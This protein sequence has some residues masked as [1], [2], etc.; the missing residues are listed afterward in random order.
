MD[1]RLIVQYLKKD[2]IDLSE[3]EQNVSALNYKVSMYAL[4]HESSSVDENICDL[5]E[6]RDLNRNVK[7]IVQM[8]SIR[9]NSIDHVLNDISD[10]IA[11]A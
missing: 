8:L 10:Q 4:L 3:I 1:S 9:C 7:R 2:G 5:S 11:E 6:I